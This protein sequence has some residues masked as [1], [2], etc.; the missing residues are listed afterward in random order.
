[1]RF[2][3][4]LASSLLF[5]AVASSCNDVTTLNDP[6]PIQIQPPNKA[7]VNMPNIAL[8]TTLHVLS[9]DSDNLLSFSNT[10][11]LASYD[12]HL[13]VLQ[14]DARMLT[15]EI[16]QGCSHNEDA[17]KIN[18]QALNDMGTIRND[19]NQM[20]ADKAEYEG[21][22]SAVEKD[23]QDVQSTS[24]GMGVDV[25]HAIETAQQREQA[26]Q[27]QWVAAQASA[28]GY[29]QQAEAVVTRMGLSIERMNC[30]EG[31]TV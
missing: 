18:N 24:S 2:Y 4:V 12:Q 25:T 13:I 28:T 20:L 14:S 29:D 6:I 9:I 5:L 23:I 11:T 7:Q 31:T 8:Q 1:M 3:K 10:G 17:Q 22:R 16:E 19:D 26:M 15:K 30:Q 21:L 27:G